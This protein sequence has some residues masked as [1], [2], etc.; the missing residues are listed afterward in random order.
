GDDDAFLECTDLQAQ[1]DASRG[2]GVDDNAFLRRRTESG[3]IGTHGISPRHKPDELKCAALSGHGRLI[4]AQRAERVRQRDR[5]AWKDRPRLVGP[6]ST[7]ASDTLG[8]SNS[9]EAERAHHDDGGASEVA[10]CGHKSLL[11]KH[12]AD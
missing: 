2:V 3:N 5:D 8:R 9:Y 1:V 11:R 6:R 12:R 7:D 4:A 10:P